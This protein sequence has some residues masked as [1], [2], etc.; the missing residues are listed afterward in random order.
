MPQLY[1]GGSQVDSRIGGYGPEDHYQMRPPYARG[2]NDPQQQQHL[3]DGR[4]HYA[5]YQNEQVE[6]IDFL[7]TVFLR[8]LTLKFM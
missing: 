4:S 8:C 2:R 1:D 3:T 7:K 6:Q 5:G